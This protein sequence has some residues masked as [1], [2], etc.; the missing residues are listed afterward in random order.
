MRANLRYNSDQSASGE[1]IAILFNVVLLSFVDRKIT[2]PVGAVI[3]ND[4]CTYFFVIRIKFHPVYI[5][6][7]ASP[8]HIVLA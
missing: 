2:E 7:S 6:L 5:I 4:V 1:D 8:V 3:G